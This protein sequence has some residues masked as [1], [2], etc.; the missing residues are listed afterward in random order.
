MKDTIRHKIPGDN[1]STGRPFTQLHVRRERWPSVQYGF[2][3]AYPVCAIWEQ[4]EHSP[5]EI[6]FAL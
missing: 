6:V 1:L 4:K 5:C 3:T 2:V